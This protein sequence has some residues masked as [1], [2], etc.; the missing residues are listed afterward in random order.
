MKVCPQ[1][2]FIYEDDQRLCDMDGAELVYDPAPPALAVAPEAAAP[3]TNTRWRRFAATAVIGVVL[4]T[5][6]VLVVHVFTLRTQEQLSTTASQ[7]TN[8]SSEQVTGDSAVPPNLDLSLPVPVGPAVDATPVSVA[9]TADALP[10]PAAGASPQ[11]PSPLSGPGAKAT[12]N[13]SSFMNLSP[14]PSQ[15]PA[16]RLARSSRRPRRADEKPRE[17]NHKE[18]GIGSLLK[19]TGRILKKPFRL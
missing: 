2:E 13:I 19:K 5:V 11:S 10:A 3:L 8:H 1:C 14:A 7:N 18:S 16:S 4:G 6:P 9:S 12:S 17:S 15:P